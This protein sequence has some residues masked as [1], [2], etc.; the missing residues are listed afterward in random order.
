MVINAI[1]TL[2]AALSDGRG[3]DDRNA[4]S[5][6]AC[7]D[8]N[9]CPG[10]DTALGVGA[11]LGSGMIAFTVIPGC[12]ALAT[13]K[14]LELKRRPLARDISM[15]LI[16]L[17]LLHTAI[18][19]GVIQTAES[20]MLVAL[21][22]VY[23]LVIMFASQAREYIRT[24]LYQLSPRRQKSFVIQASERLLQVEDAAAAAEAASGT[25]QTAGALTLQPLK[26]L[27]ALTCPECAH[28]APG[29]ARYPITLV[30]SFLWVALFSTTIA[31]IV[32]RWGSMLRIPTATLGLYVISVGAEIPDLIQSVT[33]AKRG[34]GSMAVSN[35]SGSQIINILVGLGLPWAISNAA[36]QTIRVDLVKSLH[37]MANIQLA[38][39]LLYLSLLLLPTL[40]TWGR[41]SHASLGRAKGL[42]LICIYGAALV[43]YPV[44]SFEALGVDDVHEECER[45]TND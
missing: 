13:S 14:P 26:W 44:L 31:A 35:S 2:K 23:L 41:H 25:M 27:L 24:K 4:T 45:V 32:T 20:Y 28:D 21:Y 10:S 6:C 43:L 42:I 11:I 15:Y 36:H 1:S 40:P 30:A 18:A 17:V 22:L 19:D 16:A 7:N 39:V 12:C 29:A 34:Y 3:D 8:N 9:S 5:S 37:L 33:V 38:N